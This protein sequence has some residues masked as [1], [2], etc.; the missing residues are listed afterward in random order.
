MVAKA[1]LQTFDRY[2]YG[3]RSYLYPGDCFRASGGPCYLTKD[4]EGQRLRIPMNETG[5]FTF[6]RYCECVASK[7]IEGY[8]KGSGSAIIYVGRTHHRRALR[9]CNYGRTRFESFAT[10]ERRK[11]E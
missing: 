3:K 9:A 4:D 11:L 2:R 8:R 6:I 10:A 1:K 5:V 7:W